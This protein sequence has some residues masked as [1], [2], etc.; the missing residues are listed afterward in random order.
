[1]L[2]VENQRLF[3]KNIAKLISDSFFDEDDIQKW[4]YAKDINCYAFARGLTYPDLNHELY[5]PGK[6]HNLMFGT[7][8]YIKNEY[9]PKL[10]HK[11]LTLDSKALGQTC[12]R[13]S[14]KSIKKDDGNFYFAITNF[15]PIYNKNDHHLH[16]ICRTPN[17]LW[18]HKPNW[19]QNSEVVNWIEYGK[20]F[21]MDTLLKE[22][23]SADITISSSKIRCEGNCFNEYF[24][25]LEL[26]EL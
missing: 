12:T 2:Q 1:M 5:A 6:I 10:V 4:L 26:S 21:Q 16:F 25:K 15:H 8:K 19:F 13:V 14:F 3:E 22:V 20:T 23:N 7:S 9:K 11:Y 18:L 24:Y 17:G